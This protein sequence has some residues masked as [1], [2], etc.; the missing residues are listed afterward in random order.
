MSSTPVTPGLAARPVQLPQPDAALTA[1][2]AALPAAA[3]WA[4]L[5]FA[6]TSATPAVQPEVISVRAA[7]QDALHGRGVLLDARPQFQRAQYGTVAAALAPVALDGDDPWL[8]A[9]ALAR[10]TTPILV[11]DAEPEFVDQLR[12][13]VSTPV[14]TVRGGFAAWS[15]AGLP[16]TTPALT[17][18]SQTTT[19]ASTAEAAA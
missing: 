2:L 16:R 3:H 12:T 13:Q 9:A 19:R 6:G 18:P 8:I 4:T 17:S 1:D 14:L 15:A 7:Y 10:P 5:L 11:L